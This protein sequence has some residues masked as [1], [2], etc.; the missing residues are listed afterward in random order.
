MIQNGLK[1][2]AKLVALPMALA[3]AG[4]TFAHTPHGHGS[5]WEVPESEIVRENPVPRNEQSLVRGQSLYAGHCLRCHGEKLRGDGPDG[6][7]L[8][9]PPANLIEHA[10]HHTDGDFAYRIRTGRGPMPAFKEVLDE[11][12]I[13]HLVNFLKDEARNAAFVGSSG[14]SDDHRDG[15]SQHGDHH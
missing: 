11:R 15:H 6:A 8:D 2:F 7:D 3:V 5:G 13:W 10:P 4:T 1:S 9:P 14:H 12:D